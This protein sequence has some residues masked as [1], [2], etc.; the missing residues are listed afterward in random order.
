MDHKVVG[1]V[2]AETHLG[3]SRA[4]KIVVDSQVPRRKGR[5]IQWVK[6]LM[7]KGEAI[8]VESREG[9][10]AVWVQVYLP[11]MEIN[12]PSFLLSV[13]DEEGVRSEVTPF[14]AHAFWAL[15]KLDPES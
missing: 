15:G 3:K 6:D 9:Y 12:G 11:D 8:A 7:K 13:W 2:F 10:D 5:K 1:D 14:E 4:M